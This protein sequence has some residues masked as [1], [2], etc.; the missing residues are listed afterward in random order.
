[1][2]SALSDAQ[3][4]KTLWV[5]QHLA[6][7][8]GQ[9]DDLPGDLLLPRHADV[10]HLLGF[11]PRGKTAQGRQAKRDSSRILGLAH[12]MLLGHPEQRFDG[13]RTDWQADVSQA[14]CLGGL[15]LELE[16]G[17]KLLAQ[18]SRR[19]RFHQWLTLGQGVVREPLRFENLLALKETAGIVSKPLDEGFAGGQ[20]I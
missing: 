13:I 9:G 1:M 14:E 19:H 10:K 5:T 11:L 15:Q 12:S 20:L 8:L 2:R 18:S 6:P 16:I 4:L 3:T 17:P 7:L